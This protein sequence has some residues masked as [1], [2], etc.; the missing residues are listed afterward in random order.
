MTQFQTKEEQASMYLQQVATDRCEDQTGDDHTVRENRGVSLTS[1]QFYYYNIQI[2]IR[3]WVVL[4]NA[5][6]S[7]NII[8]T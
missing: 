1:V 3:A 2:R 7:L 5:N 8:G 6:L 4:G